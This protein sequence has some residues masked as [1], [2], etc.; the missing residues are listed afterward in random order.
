MQETW[1]QS[2][3]WEDPLEKGKAPHNIL[4]QRI[5]WTV[6]GVAKTRTW[7]SV[8]FHFPGSRHGC[9][10]VRTYPELSMFS[11]RKLRF[12]FWVRRNLVS[13]GRF[14]ESSWK[15]VERVSR[16]SKA[17][18]FGK[19]LQGFLK[20]KVNFSLSSFCGVGVGG[21]GKAINIQLWLEILVSSINIMVFT[22]LRLAI[23]VT[24]ICFRNE[25]SI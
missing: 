25:N 15:K 9:K 17:K 12:E 14:K 11:W 20:S 3:G 7:L 21:T 10:H 2:L 24:R 22:H 1:F 13:R 5:P 4:A 18:W 6:D 16:L 8:H 19:S 23:E